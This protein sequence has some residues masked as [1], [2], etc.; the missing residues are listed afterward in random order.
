MS[1]QIEYAQNSVTFSADTY[2][3]GEKVNCPAIIAENTYNDGNE[4]LETC[5]EILEDL[6]AE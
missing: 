4:P 5:E 2:I 1:Y 6:K 3:D